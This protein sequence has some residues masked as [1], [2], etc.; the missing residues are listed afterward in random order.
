MES[1]ALVKSTNN[2]VACRFFECTP[3]WLLL[4]MNGFFCWFFLVVCV[5]IWPFLCV[6]IVCVVWDAVFGEYVG[7]PHN[8][9]WYIFEKT[10]E[11][12]NMKRRVEKNIQN[13]AVQTKLN[14]YINKYRKKET[15]QM[16]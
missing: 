5:V 11:V 1:K 12:H 16:F 9:C 7:S 6:K 15:L 4:Y 2:I 14:L 10:N 8:L 3:S 13:K